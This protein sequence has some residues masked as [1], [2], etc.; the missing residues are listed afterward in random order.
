MKRWSTY[1]GEVPK[2]VTSK[3]GSTTVPNIVKTKKKPNQHR[4]SRAER[5]TKIL[6]N[7]YQGSKSK[8]EKFDSL[9]FFKGLGLEVKPGHGKKQGAKKGMTSK[10]TSMEG[11]STP[12]DAKKMYP[13][14]FDSIDL[15]STPK[16]NDQDKSFSWIDLPSPPIKRTKKRNFG[17]V[18]STP[19]LSALFKDINSP[20]KKKSTS[21]TS[22]SAF[23]LLNLTKS[24]ILDRES[25]RCR[26]KSIA[27]RSNDTAEMDRVNQDTSFQ[28]LE[29]ETSVTQTFLREVS[30]LD[31]MK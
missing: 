1:T 31:G 3:S 9:D 21:I 6:K 24:L 19:K 8:K 20:P 5:A 29:S 4:S 16:A 10:K 2:T 28:L 13:D 14:A 30:T 7:K 12:K 26:G 15:P 25:P 17:K 27:G 18:N 22:I 11:Q 23:L